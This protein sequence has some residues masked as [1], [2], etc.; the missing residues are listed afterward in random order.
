MEALSGCM[1]KESWWGSL[2]SALKKTDMPDWR[3]AKDFTNWIKSHRGCEV[4]L[5]FDEA[6]VLTVVPL[7][8][9]ND[10][11]GALRALKTNQ[12][13]DKQDN[14]VQVHI[15]YHGRTISDE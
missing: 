14:P 15:A 11:L 5:L 4:V 10:F 13:L 3:E 1:T 2:C 6:D 12:V 9:K 8:V 7:E